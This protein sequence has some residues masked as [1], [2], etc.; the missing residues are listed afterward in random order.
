MQILK[1][2]VCINFGILDPNEILK[3][4]VCEI[5]NEKIYDEYTGLPNYGGINDPRLGTVHRD[6]I[7]F[8]CRFG[9]D[10]CTGHFG[11]INLA[12]PVYYVGM[13]EHLR[14]ILKCICFNCSKILLRDENII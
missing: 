8:T 1:K 7:C 2:P 9:P 4:S 11:N 12:K 3:H 5:N 13:I 14:K 6:K 10:V